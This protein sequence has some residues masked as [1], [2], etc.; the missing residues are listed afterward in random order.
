MGFAPASDPDG[1]NDAAQH[2]ILCAVFV[3][4]RKMAYRA[5]ISRHIN[6]VVMTPRKTGT[7]DDH[8]KPSPGG[9]PL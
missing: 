1:P 7:S 2:T 6:F 3:K 4:R 8:T 5:A 9:A